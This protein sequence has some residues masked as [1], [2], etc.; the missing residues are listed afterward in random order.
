MDM[1]S[2]PAPINSRAHG[3]AQRVR[4]ASLAQDPAEANAFYAPDML[5]AALDHLT[6]QPNIRL[7]ESFD[8]GELIGLLP[9]AVASRHGRLPIPCV[10]NWMHEHCFFGAPLIRKGREIAAWRS[11]LA[12]LDAAHWAPGFLHLQGLDAAG[13]NAACSA[14]LAHGSAPR[15]SARRRRPPQRPHRPPTIPNRPFSPARLRRVFWGR[16]NAL[17]TRA[18]ARG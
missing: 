9:V 3:P 15:D 7:I 12:Q 18:T 8:N 11:F 6:G 17:P 13:A 1:A 10:S 16:S 14:L 4:W 5:C 2:H